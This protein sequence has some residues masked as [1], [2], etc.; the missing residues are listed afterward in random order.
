VNFF[1]GGRVVGR[2]PI[3]SWD[4]GGGCYATETQFVIAAEH[5]SALEAF[6]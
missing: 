2:A 1:L 4:S 3:P 5:V 6:A